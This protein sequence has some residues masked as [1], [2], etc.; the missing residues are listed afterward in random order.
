MRHQ[1]LCLALC[2][3]APMM[4][5]AQPD[6]DGYDYQGGAEDYNNKL[7]D[8]H[9]GCTASRI[10]CGEWLEDEQHERWLT[11]QEDWNAERDSLNAIEAARVEKHRRDEWNRMTPAGR[12][13]ILEKR[14]KR[15][16]DEMLRE[17]K[18]KRRSDS[19]R[20]VNAEIVEMNKIIERQNALIINLLGVSLLTLVI[21]FMFIAV[22]R[23]FRKQQREYGQQKQQA[24]R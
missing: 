4:A 19:I 2:V 8:Y 14:R 3:L 24:P 17:E 21:T 7:D 9:G 20:V 13:A 12:R 1:P 22:R 5:K 18:S 10:V 15:I 11:R 23:D 6:P 16:E